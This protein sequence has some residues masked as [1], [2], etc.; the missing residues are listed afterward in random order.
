MR[1][2]MLTDEELHV[3]SEDFTKFLVVQGI[4][5]DLWR[6]INTEDKEKAVQIVEIFSDTVLTKVYSKIKYLSFLSND[7][8]SLFK[9]EKDT[10]HLILIKKTKNGAGFKHVDDVYRTLKKGANHYELYTSSKELKEKLLDEIHKLSVQG[11]LIS[12]PEIWD[13]I[14][15]FSKKTSK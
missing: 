7:V 11:C 1:F 13:S 9:I 14:E 12:S 15:E 8:F 10:M 3:L 6:K 5:D 4:D 2:R